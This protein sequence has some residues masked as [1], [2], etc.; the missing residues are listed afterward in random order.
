MRSAAARLA[1]L[2]LAASLAC[3]AD[4]PSLDAGVCGNGVID[5]GEDCDTYPVGPGTSCRPP[6]D[7]VGQCRLDCTPGSG[8]ACP[9]GW[10]CGT[11]AVC[12]EPNGSFVRQQQVVAADAWR[13]AMG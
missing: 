13:L 3:C 8:H 6:G 9:S 1:S 10:G 7:P 2:A 5:P 11:D 4:L 12:R